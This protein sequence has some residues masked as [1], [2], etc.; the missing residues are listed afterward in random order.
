MA[1]VHRAGEGYLVYAKGAF[2]VLVEHCSHILG[3]DGEA[4][5]TDKSAWEEEVARLASSGLRTLAFAFKPARENPIEDTLLE[6]LVFLGVIGFMDPA[7]KD[8][9]PVF[10]VYK[11][12]GIRVVMVTG[13]H[14]RTALKVSEEVGLVDPENGE[15]TV[16]TGGGSIK[17]DDLGRARVFAR[18]LPQEKLELVTRFQ[19]GGHIVGMIGDGINDVPALKKADIGIAMGI[20]GTEAAREAA[21]VILKDDSFGAI[22]LA[23]RQGRVVFGNIRQFVRY[24]LS[25]NLAEIL[26]V[27][28]AAMGNLPAPLL[29]L[30]ILF[31]NLVTDVFPALALGLGRGPADIMDRAPANPGDPIVK[32][33]EWIRILLY[34]FALG[35][36]VLG[37]VLYGK[38][39]L[40]LPAG[41]INNLAFYTLVGAQL[42]H[43]LNM[44]GSGTAFVR[45]EIASNGYVWGAL[46]ISLGITAA[47]Y[48]IPPVASVL[49]LE[50]IHPGFL[51]TALLFSL[52]SVLL[53]QLIKHI[54]G[55]VSG[56]EVPAL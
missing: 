16:F 40:D 35:A 13:D 53:V 20:R 55:K 56:K 6:D 31:L 30:Q 8:I 43:V 22:E 44:A 37:A 15:S 23:I 34:G 38:Y 45:H 48:W 24:L 19:G 1:T 27:A 39:G 18:V 4:P 46:F 12:A 3:P 51:G 28:V 47:A 41:R 42:L 9:R 33:S 49:G 10:E 29:P 32:R 2:E 54:L 50:R 26:A 21:D 25:C 14:P 36:S 7:R 17:D 11:K 5:F 52:G